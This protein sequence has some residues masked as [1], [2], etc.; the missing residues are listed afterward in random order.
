MTYISNSTKPADGLVPHSRYT[1]LRTRIQNGGAVK[2]VNT[3]TYLFGLNFY[4][5][6][7]YANTTS[8]PHL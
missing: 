1:L 4:T 2:T 8:F 6:T 5:Y 7:I 3:N